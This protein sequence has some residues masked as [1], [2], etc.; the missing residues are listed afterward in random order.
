MD[1]L[2]RIFMPLKLSD[3]SS[4]STDNLPVSPNLNSPYNSMQPESEG[5]VNVTA[6]AEL[7]HLSVQG[8]TK[9]L[10]PEAVLS[11]TNNHVSYGLTTDVGMVRTNN[12]D[13]LYAFASNMRGALNKPDFGLFIV[14]DGMGG[15][16]DGEKASALTVN[17]IATQLVQ[18]LYLSILDD[19]SEEEHIPIT[20]SLVTALQRANASIID[21]VPDGG[22]TA[23][24]VAI[25]NDLAYIVHVGDTRVYLV[26][27]NEIEQLTRDHSL[28][29]RLIELGQLTPEEAISHPQRNV[30][31][32]ALGQ[33]P[34]LEVDAITRRL[35]SSSRILICSDGLWNS[36]PEKTILESMVQGHSPQ[37]TCEKLV[38]LA[39]IMGGSDNITA[40][41]IYMPGA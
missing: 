6:T 7:P 9:P 17:T 12:Q 33:N 4:S 3:K 5:V 34:H 23:T 37:S 2:R 35:T 25:V 36:V 10:A 18:Q 31:Y 28:V 13:T 14:A 26:S 15:H 38:S 30:L 22:T 32:R 1:F 8:A 24:V 21:K 41:V 29:Q 40:I 20:E 39:N 16:H 11:S 19:E 27:N